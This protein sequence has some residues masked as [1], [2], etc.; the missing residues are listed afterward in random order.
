M[1]YGMK[2][3]NSSAKVIGETKGNPSNVILFVIS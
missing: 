2:P 3:L 1:V